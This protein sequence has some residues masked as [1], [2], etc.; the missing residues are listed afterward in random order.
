[1]KIWRRLL[2]LLFVLSL[3]LNL[4]ACNSKGS[5]VRSDS[6]TG[7]TVVSV[8]DFGAKGDNL[9]D[10]TKAFKDA[11]SNTPSGC[12]LNVPDGNYAIKSAVIVD[13]KKITINCE[14]GAVFTNS[15]G[16]AIFKKQDH[17]N[18]FTI[19]NATFDVNGI[20][21][22]GDMTDSDTF[23][24]DFSIENCTFGGSGTGIKL[25]GV[26]E[27]F[28]KDCYFKTKTGIYLQRTVNPVIDRC[29]F[30]HNTMAIYYDGDLTP[31][32]AGLRVTNCTMLDPVEA[33]K[34]AYCDYL[35]VSGCMIDYCVH[36]IQIL[37]QDGCLIEGNYIT[38][39]DGNPAIAVKPGDAHPN[40]SS[41]HV[42]I[43]NNTIATHNTVANVVSAIELDNVEDCLIQ[44]NNIGFWSKYGIKF[45]NM[46]TSQIKN[47]VISPL[48]GY[49]KYSIY[50][51]SNSDDSSNLISDNIVGK[52]IKVNWARTDFNRGDTK[53]KNTNM[54]TATIV[55]G[56]T[57][58]TV[59][60]GMMA[61]PRVV[62]LTPSGNVGSYWVSSKNAS[63]FVITIP[64]RLE[65]NITFDWLAISYFSALTYN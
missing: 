30:D 64:A 7:N 63:T 45:N 2:G 46:I 20:A 31:Y 22:L 19:K 53:S 38:S 54:G 33:I 18:L 12:E 37:G 52:D 34:V 27:S 14:P 50:N 41:K 62:L 43:L 57:S 4:T 26:R 35:E 47:N 6:T 28:I 65:S 8:T 17:G 21:I 61:T 44:G 32:S 29:T 40:E 11:I 48:S 23:Y 16:N 42:K 13:G 24:N 58:V 3:L 25:V 60:H 51:A 49:G 5:A 9:T 39:K 10:D 55:A 36:P 59:S 56:K 15:N 1:M